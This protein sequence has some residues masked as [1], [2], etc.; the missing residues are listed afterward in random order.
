MNKIELTFMLDNFNRVI[1]FPQT[2]Q[3]QIAKGR[4]LG[5]GLSGVTINLDAD[6]V[7]LVLPEELALGRYKRW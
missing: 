5:F 6:V 7:T 3:L 4:L 1:L 2:E